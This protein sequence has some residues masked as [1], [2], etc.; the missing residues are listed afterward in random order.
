MQQ[1]TIHCI[2]YNSMFKRLGIP[3]WI[4]EKKQK[5]VHFKFTSDLSALTL[6]AFPAGGGSPLNIKLQC[7]L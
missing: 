7:T 5:H 3:K 1:S 6:P 4:A 2:P